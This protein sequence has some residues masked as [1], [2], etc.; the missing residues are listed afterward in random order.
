MYQK[1]SCCNAVKSRACF[2]LNNLKLVFVQC[3][4]ADVLARH[5]LDTCYRKLNASF[6]PMIGRKE[7]YS[8]YGMANIIGSD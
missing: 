4:H 2:C 5:V 1:I 6:C 8:T 7:I 3:Y